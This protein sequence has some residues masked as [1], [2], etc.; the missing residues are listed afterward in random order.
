VNAGSGGS[1]DDD[2]ASCCS[3]GACMCAHPL[4]GRGGAV[5]SR[6][7]AQ[8]V[9]APFARQQNRADVTL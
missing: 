4:G 3:T 2:Q 5:L 1:M 9:V 7:V 8:I 6:L